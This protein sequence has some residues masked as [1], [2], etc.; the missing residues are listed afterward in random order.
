[1]SERDAEPDAGPD[2]A[3]EYALGVMDGAERRAVE[4]RMRQDGPFAA[5]VAW[6]QERLA[7][8]NSQIAPENPPAEVWQRVEADLD[9]IARVRDGARDQRIESL[10]RAARRGVSPIWRTLA[11]A[12]SLLAVASLGAIAI[13]APGPAD[14]PAAISNETLTAR[15]TSD[16]GQTLF[17]VVLDLQARTATLV[18]VSTIDDGSRVPELWLLPPGGAAPRSLGVLAEGRPLRL[19]LQGVSDET[20]GSSLAISLE[21]QGGSPTGA[22][23]G[24][25]VA[26]GA[27]DRI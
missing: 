2:P 21:P 23:T 18:P 1:M 24:P 14:N 13:W 17:T 11:V 6:W 25:V 9:R 16:T 27:L 19:V 20:A 22:P 5:R 8:L 26:T 3:A 7:P 4:R 12:S 15:L 10:A